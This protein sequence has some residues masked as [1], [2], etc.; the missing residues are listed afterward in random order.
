MAKNTS[1]RSKKTSFDFSK[2]KGER[3][4][5]RS[6]KAVMRM[7]INLK[8]HLKEG[9]EENCDSKNTPLLLP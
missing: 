1:I 7:K 5:W 8:D 6:L 3:L 9:Q 4:R 2:S